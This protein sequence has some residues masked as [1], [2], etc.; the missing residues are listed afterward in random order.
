MKPAQLFV[1][2]L[3]VAIAGL[4]VPLTAAEKTSS[5]SELFQPIPFEALDKQAFSQW[6]SGRESPQALDGKPID[7]STVVWTVSSEPKLQGV[8]FGEGKEGGRRHL[9]IGLVEAL[10]IGSVLVRGGG[11]LSVLKP[12]AEYPGDLAD[13]SQWIAAA[14]IVDGKVSADEVDLEGLVLWTLPPDTQTRAL[15][16]SHT[17][18]P[19][20]REQAGWLG[21]VWMNRERVANV[22]PQAQVQSAARDDVSKKLANESNDRTWRTW[23]NGEHGAALPISPEHPAIVT[24]T[25]PRT[26]ELSG[27]SLIW[28]GCSAAQVDTFTGSDQEIIAEAASD[29][30]QRVAGQSDFETLW[31][32]PLGPHWLAFEK[33]LTTRALRLRITG[34]QKVRNPNLKGKDFDGHRVWL[35]EVM[36]LAPLA[37]GTSLSSMVLP[38]NESEPPPIPVRFTLPKPGVVTLVIEDEGGH[39]VRNLVSETP[40]PAGENVAWWDGSDDLLRDPEAFRHGL[41]HIPT[42]PVAP[43]NYQVRGLWHEPLALRYEFSIY[44]AG[45]PAWETADGTGCWLTTHTPPTSA[46]I[47]PGSRTRDGQPLVF[48]GAYV[49]EGGHGLQWMHEDGTKLGGQHWIG[50]AWTGAPTIAVDTGDLAVPEHL[51]YVGSAWEGELRLTAKSTKFTDVPI[52]KHQF[53]EEYSPRP[54]KPSSVVAPPVIEGFDGGT[55]IWLLSGIAARDAEIVCS[56]LRQ[57]ELLVVDVQKNQI[58]Q[59][60]P[61]DNPR[62]LAF[63]SRGRLLALS[64]KKLVR[65]AALTEK[66]QVVIDTGLEDPRHVALDSNDN[67]FITDRSTSHQVKKFSANFR[68]QGAIGKPGEPSVGPYDPLHM[69]NPNGLAVDS[70]SRVWVTEADSSPRRV[71]VWSVD[72]QLL[73]TFY[74]PTEYGGGGCLDPHDKTRFYYKG[75]E[76]KLDWD[77]GTDELVNV[78]YRP[79]RDQPNPARPYWPDTPLYPPQQPESQ[80][81]TSCYTHGMAGSHVAFVW[82][83]E[84]GVARLVAAVGDGQQ[85]PNLLTGEFLPLWPENTK[86]LVQYPKPDEFATFSWTDGNADGL[87]QPSE[88]K[89]IRQTTR[90]VT[91]MPDLAFCVSRFGEI[92][93][94]FVPTFDADGLPHYDLEHP[95]SLGPTTDRPVSDGGDQTL[96][97]PGGWTVDTTAPRPYSPYGLGGKF[98][99]ESRWSYP[100]PWPGLHPSHEAAVPDQPGM[101]VGHTRLLGGLVQG[102]LGP[103]FCVNSNMGCM[104]LFTADGLFISTLFHDSRTAPFWNSP[105]ATRNMDLSGISLHDENFWPSITQVPDGQIYLIDGGRTSLVRIDGLDTLTPIE[106]TT[107]TV[108]EA[109]LDRARDWFA[110]VETQRHARQGSGILQVPLGGQ[111]P[112]VDGNLADWPATTDWAS[113]DRRGTRANF[114]STSKPFEVS[115]AVTIANDRLFA[116]WRT[117]EKDLLNNSGE[118]PLALFKHGGCLD[119]MLA[120]DPD[121]PAGRSEAT[122][123]DERLLITRVNKQTR[124]LLYRAKVPGAKDPV[125]F[126]SPWRTIY[127]D[128]VEDVSQEVTL[129]DDK[130]GNFEISIPLSALHFKP[131]VGATYQA[132]LGVLR[133]SGGQTM[134]RVYWSN[135]ATVITADVPSEAEL[136]PKLWGKWKVFAP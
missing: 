4:L 20:D 87:P 8:K 105:V 57:N 134:Q 50:G 136:A 40:F 6:V 54:K 95:E 1:F 3:V 93:A 90:G 96:V 72:G 41:Y 27:V 103:M 117:T 66:P 16:F 17:P 45:K 33:P 36:A 79:N 92:N 135:K 94:R 98:K 85:W 14:R 107:V 110:K 25:W 21:G 30:W 76:F 115:A 12:G 120:T 53:G 60:I 112:T 61:L 26:V 10:P 88:V 133:G 34:V 123:G 81:F 77:K 100:S 122:L 49:A 124:A 28:A 71:S 15:R 116:A 111:A 63:D 5:S 121:A 43:G 18:T 74:G 68:P 109:D 70:Q 82:K 104:Y 46:A 132:D 127:L 51:C 32:L 38:T 102:K 7:P 39:R 118:T 101:V 97:D 75:L 126:S 73:R 86:P 9:R 83:L 13:D 48:L 64:G 47:L 129:A 65:F 31:P 84:H 113:I 23:D 99:G 11:T 128:A 78:F 37:Q 130:M 22:A 59:H 52:L 19:G 44:T 62:G 119:I 67:L 29:R 131:K 91:V 35:G 55:R 56:M 114:A 69:N 2:A 89:F 58:T 80:Y 42:R 24:L 106:P 125:N 108:T